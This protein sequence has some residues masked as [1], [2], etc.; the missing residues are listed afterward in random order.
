MFVLSRQQ[1]LVET[2]FSQMWMTED[3]LNP[4]QCHRFQHFHCVKIVSFCWV[5]A[6]LPGVVR[7]PYP[8]S[9]AVHYQCSSLANLFCCYLGVFEISLGVAR[10]LE[11]GTKQV[12]EV[13]KKFPVGGKSVFV[14]HPSNGQ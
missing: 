12:S 11:A 14:D 6:K 3:L 7:L 13:L 5:V 9:N 1:A 8:L 2:I 4:C 10:L